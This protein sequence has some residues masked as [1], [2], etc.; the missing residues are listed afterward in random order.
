VHRRVWFFCVLLA[1]MLPAVASAGETTIGIALTGTHGTHRESGGVAQAPLIPAP[2]LAISHRVHRFELTAEGLPPLGPIGVANNGL[3]MRD[4]SLTYADATLRYW[5]ASG[6]L[7]FGAGQT[8]YNQRTRFVAFQDAYEQLND[9]NRSRISG[10]RYE[11]VG[12]VPLGRGDFMEAQFAVNPRLHGRYTVMRQRVIK[13]TGQSFGFTSPPQGEAASQVDIGLRFVH[14]FAPFAVSY[15]V[16]YL[17]YTAAFT[18]PGSPFA[19]SNSLVMPFV[20][21]ERH[22]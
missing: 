21:L 15:G 19:D 13:A 11:V 8:L 10:M 2:V 12:R 7:A 14:G 4:I 1:L 16:R 20:A 6:T 9:V 22:F 17:N 3:G 18:R 5:N